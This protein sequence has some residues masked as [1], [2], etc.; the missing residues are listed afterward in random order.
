MNILK[1][2]FSAALAVTAL[3]GCSGEAEMDAVANG[4][5]ETVSQSIM[6]E[7]DEVPNNRVPGPARSGELTLNAVNIA[8]LYFRM[9]GEPASVISM[10]AKPVNKR[11][12]DEF[13]RRRFVDEN[14]SDFQKVV[15]EAVSANIYKVLINGRLEDY[16]FE[17]EGF[18]LG[19]LFDRTFVA[20][21]GS[22]SGSEGMDFALSLGNSGELDFLKM[23]PE[24]AESLN[25][26]QG[27][28]KVDLIVSFVPIQAGWTRPRDEVFRTVDAIATKVQ[29]QTKDGEVIGS[30][31]AT[32]LP[33][34]GPLM[35]FA[36]NPFEE[37]D[38]V[39]PWLAEKAPE[40][41]LA[42]YSWIIDEN[43]RISQGNMDTGDSFYD[44][45]TLHGAA[46]SGCLANFGYSECQRLASARSEFI[47]RC[48]SEM[49]ADRRAQCYAIK[50][51][52]YTEHEASAR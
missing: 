29:V 5:K 14:L 3:A 21:D 34:D 32:T 22:R 16:D 30:R 44:T 26:G 48:V 42:R 27:S 38:L 24:K 25:L 45:M 40:A 11:F 13:S 52:P 49:P 20:F 12:D 46:A 51:F 2:A 33:P 8:H 35:L 19:G 28:R 18:P 43:W 47:N 23:S 9:S 17:R 31:N 10:M 41:V 7:S 1:T 36:D 37:A 50:E 39:N 6:A 4:E 15:D